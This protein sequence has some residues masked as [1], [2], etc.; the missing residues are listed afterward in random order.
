MKYST[1][2]K[3][4]NEQKGI[5]RRRFI[6]IAGI[7]TIGISSVRYIN[8][9]TK[10]VSIVIDPADQISGSQPS[11]WAVKELEKTLTTGGIN[12]YRCTKISQARDGDLCIVAAGLG[13]AIARQLLED[14]NKKIPSVPE[15]LGLIP[16]RS[17]DKQVLLACGYDKRGIVYALLELADRVNYSDEPFSSIDIGKPVIEQPANV[18]RSVNRLF[19]AEIEDKPWYYDREMCGNDISQC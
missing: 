1:N 10:G 5:S 15:A 12:V 8:F 7:S 19:V 3:F 18:I 14:S 11:Q 2:Q 16:V 13:S 4:S 9:Q 17:G 6:K